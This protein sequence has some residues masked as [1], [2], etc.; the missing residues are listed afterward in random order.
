MPT[1][2]FHYNGQAFS[3]NVTD[4][5]MQKPEENQVTLLKSDLL[6]KY[7]DARHKEIK[8][9]GFLDYLALLERPAQAIKVGLKESDI[10]GNLFR[11]AGGV[12]LTPEEGFLKGAYRGLMGEDEVRTQDFLPDNMNPVLKGVLGFAGDVATDPLTFL[13]GSVVGKIAS[14]ARKHT[15]RAVAQKLQDF[16]E[17]AV[18]A[19]IKGYGLP[20]VGRWFNVPVG[21]AAK[22]VKGLSEQAGKDLRNRERVLAE[23]LPKLD[24][25][26]KERAIALGIS[27]PKLK[28][29]FRNLME[30]PAGVYGIEGYDPI[31]AADELGEEGMGLLKDWKGRLDTFRKEEQAY[32][33][34]YEK[35][36]DYF[37]HIITPAG[38][39]QIA[40]GK[41]PFIEGFD[42]LGQPIYKAG[43][44]RPR[45]L[46]G[47]VETIN[48]AKL[49]ATGGRNPNPVDRLYEDQFFH[50]DPTVAL[51]LRWARHNK[52]LQRKW[53]IDE[54]TDA[55]RA[56]G[57]KGKNFKPELGI[58]RWIKP[59]P[60][61]KGSYLERYMDLNGD[62]QWRAVDNIDDW[63]VVKG[64]P[65]HSME[66]EVREEWARVFKTVSER[67]GS[68]ITGAEGAADDAARIMEEALTEKFMAPKQVARQL[69]DH[70]SLM[71]GDVRGEEALDKFLKFYD[72]TQ[73]A[74]KAWTLGVRPAYHT[75]N[76]LGN[77]LNAYTITGLGENIPKA[78]ETF[79]NAAK[80]QYYAKME[81]SSLKRQ[82]LIDNFSGIGTTFK[83]TP[84]KIDDA[85][86]E[87]EFADTGFTMEQIVD[88][89]IGRGINAGH[90]RADIVREY[91]SALASS[92]GLGSKL[93]RV[94]GPDNPLVRGG[95]AFGG[96]IEGNARYAVFLDTLEKIKKNP[97]DW[98]WKAP[99]GKEIK[100]SEFTKHKYYT[101]DVVDSIKNPGELVQVRR[102]MNKSEAIFDVAG[103]QVKKALFDYSDVS[104]FE[105]DWAK[106]AMPFYTWTRK[107]IPAQLKSLVQN[108]QRAEKLHLA[109]EQF[110]YETGD[111]DYSDYG[112]M[113]GDRVPIFL[114]KEK[115]GVVQGFMALNV[116][117]MADLQRILK[118]K[119]LLAEMTSPLIKAPL[120]LLNNY[121]SF[122]KKPITT[123]P[124]E[125]K[126]F[127]GVALPPKLW[128]L[129]QL[130]VPLVEINRVNPAGV[131]GEQMV[132]PVTGKR[133]ITEAF[134][135]LGARRE[136]NPIDAPEVARW[137]RFFTGATVYDVNLRKQRYFMN[138]N[139]KRD[140]TDL[141]GQL[142]WA[143]AN[144]RTRTADRLIEVLEELDRQ[145]ITDPLDRRN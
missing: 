69:E 33:L 57:Q 136:S 72:E 28:G 12:D 52:A 27:T 44:R 16:K 143:K 128:H 64:F 130:I 142:K 65:K 38:R 29:S 1:I 17:Y 20:D 103:Q 107:N 49:E 61:N 26:F 10:G 87:K 92:Q 35:M 62:Y 84:P 94:L 48:A 23:E 9:K 127:L 21:R 3:A 13:G 25:F 144:Q 45:E 97:S 137:L 31:R 43:F 112:A 51:G 122:R 67:E 131:F 121:D 140:A 80:L 125:S 81:G 59:D 139:F 132:D 66:D 89:A 118:P 70:L 106:R 126:D 73:N 88:A 78:V 141:K 93:H 104:R 30:D 109:K 68:T 113:W 117:P 34:T 86:W 42:D 100:L 79:G 145:E 123:I 85:L 46:E 98:T 11:A 55:R 96:T 91:E 2:N 18:N 40:E 63:A 135:G 37:P 4:E 32:G 115:H 95:F 56:V 54:M 22:A 129:A 60:A 75:R 82:E 58:G 83:D 74:W 5:F 8:D 116:V 6:A 24:K 133:T 47:P 50:E 101:T 71:S 102:L 114:G 36:E 138:K 90:Y 76:A 7:G 110:E 105:R 41:H 15:P 53:Y 111:L 39:K 14:G 120:E 77:I 119:P 124:G 108:P 134:G 99:D 19:D